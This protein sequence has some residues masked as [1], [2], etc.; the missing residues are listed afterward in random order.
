M[1]TNGTSVTVTLDTSPQLSAVTFSSASSYVLQG[2]GTNYLTLSATSGVAL[3]TVSAGSHTIAAPLVLASSSDFAPASGT[4]LILSGAISG[5]GGLSLSNAGTLILSG[6]NTYS[7]G[8]MVSGGTLVVQGANASS[9]F[10]ASDG[11]TLQF[12]GASVSLGSASVRAAS[13]GNVQYQNATITGGFLRGPGTHTTLPGSSNSFTAVTT[14]AST[15]FLQNGSDIFTGF[16]NGGQVTNNAPLTWDGGENNIGG[17]LTV[18]NIVSTDDFV[19]A[20]TITITSGG[21][22]NNHLS[23]MTSG[24]GGQITVNYGG[25]LNADSRAEGVALDLQ[26]SLLVNNGIVTGTTNVNYG[27]TVQGSGQFGPINVFDG[28]T[29]DIS[30]SASPIATSLAVSSGSIAGAGRSALAGTIA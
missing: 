10:T 15:N 28:G 30:P 2:G 12:S 16:T 6:S 14:Y 27:A 20:G 13:G 8:T 5:P 26:D 18:N 1:A 4:Q 22:F 19:N 3:V 11:G 24:G 25:T 17:S 7:G 23:D 9:S 21:V 29:L